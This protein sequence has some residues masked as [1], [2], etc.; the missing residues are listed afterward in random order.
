MDAANIDP[1]DAL[2]WRNAGRWLDAATHA[3][4]LDDAVAVTPAAPGPRL[5][6]VGSATEDVAFHRMLSGFGPL[7]NLQPYGQPW[8]ACHAGG[9][10]LDGLLRAVATYPLH[11]RAAPPRRFGEALLDRLDDCDL[12]ISQVDANDYSFGWEVPPLR[13][14]LAAHGV[15]LVYLGFR[16]F[17][18]DAAWLAIAQQ[19]IEE[20][21]P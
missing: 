17:R 21:L 18:P 12:V 20:A 8:P 9:P 14:A 1:A 7:T 3:A 11:I 10:D 19:R 15:P 4:L 6:L 2:V 5:G 16:P 13:D